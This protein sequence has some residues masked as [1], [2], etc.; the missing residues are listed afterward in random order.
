MI[1]PAPSG[2][3]G[4]GFR[5]RRGAHDTTALASYW[6]GEPPGGAAFPANARRLIRGRSPANRE[7]LRPLVASKPNRTTRILPTVFPMIPLPVAATDFMIG[8]SMISLRVTRIRLLE[9]NFVNS[10]DRKSQYYRESA[11]YTEKAL[12]LPNK[13]SVCNTA[14]T[15]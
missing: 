11:Q 3:G 4:L 7:R 14:P 15:M 9:D 10:F 5:S 8:S 2:V 1:P 12:G 13:R 6:G